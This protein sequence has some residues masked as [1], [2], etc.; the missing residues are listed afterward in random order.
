VEQIDTWFSSEVLLTLWPQANL[1]RSLELSGP[2]V[3]V[4]TPVTLHDV[5]VPG[6]CI[7]KTLPETD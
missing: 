7:W 4:G 5:S 2:P 3:P 6:E 1:V